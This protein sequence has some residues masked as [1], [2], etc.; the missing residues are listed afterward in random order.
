MKTLIANIGLVKRL[1]SSVS[2][3]AKQRA[4]AVLLAVAT[5]LTALVVIPITLP[6]PVA[7]AVSSNDVY[8]NNTAAPGAFYTGDVMTS[9]VFYAKA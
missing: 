6:A 8:T 9:Y 5:L 4:I 2:P 1:K 7:G 3:K